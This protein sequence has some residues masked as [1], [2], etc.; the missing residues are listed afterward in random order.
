MVKKEEVTG[1]VSTVDSKTLEILKPVKIETNLTRT[2]SECDIYLWAPGAKL[3]IRIRVLLNGENGPTTMGMLEN[4][5]V[6]SNDIETITVLKDA[7]AAIYGTIGANG[8]ILITT[9]TG[10]RIQSQ[11]LVYS[12]TGFRKQQNRLKCHRHY[13]SMKVMQTENSV[14]FLM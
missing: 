7:Q 6:K 5:F 9:K 8:V 4:R 12:H 14:P 10:K 13:C 11:E 3:D 1:A 2:V